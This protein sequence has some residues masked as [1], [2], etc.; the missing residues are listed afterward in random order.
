MQLVIY[1]HESMQ[2]VIYHS[3]RRPPIIVYVVDVDIPF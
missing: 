2:L 3:E 1:H